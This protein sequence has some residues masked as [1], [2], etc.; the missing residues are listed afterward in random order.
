M[1]AG[2]SRL[3][4]QVARFHQLQ[5]ESLAVQLECSK[6]LTALRKDVL[7][8]AAEIP[9]LPSPAAAA[10]RRAL[11]AVTASLTEVSAI[12]PGTGSLFVRALLGRVNVRVFSCADRALLKTAHQRF[13]DQTAVVYVLLPAAVTG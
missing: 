8:A 7:R 1:R 5:A 3:L 12:K 13:R 9:H 10:R 6:G 4:S 11:E 2:A